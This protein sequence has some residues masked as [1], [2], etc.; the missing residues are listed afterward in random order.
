MCR[1]SY[2]VFCI[3]ILFQSK[4]DAVSNPSNSV[5][6]WVQFTLPSKATDQAI[7]LYSEFFTAFGRRLRLKL[8]RLADSN[9]LKL[10]LGIDAIEVDAAAVATTYSFTVDAFDP[11]TPYTR[12]CICASPDELSVYGSVAPARL[13]WAHRL[14]EFSDPCSGISHRGKFPSDQMVANFTI[15]RHV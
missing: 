9:T 5:S 8:Q 7:G 4:A 6:V 2:V 11:S 10:C 13:A 12:A 3:C 14:A 1:V 15:T